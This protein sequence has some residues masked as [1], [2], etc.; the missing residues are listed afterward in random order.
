MRSLSLVILLPLAGCLTPAGEPTP[1]R[2]TLD[3]G[4]F[5]VGDVNEGLLTLDSPLGALDIPL[6]DIGEVEPVEGQD[7]AGSGDHVRVWLR[8][9]S[10]LV[11]RWSEPEL[12]VDIAIGGGVTAGA[13]PMAQVQR[14]QLTGEAAFPDAGTFRVK[15]AFGDDVFVDAAET[16]LPLDTQL[17]QL[18]PLL[19]E[20]ESLRPLDDQG[21]WRVQL[22]TGTVLNGTIATDTLTLSLRLG[23]PSIEVGVDDLLAV[24]RMTY[25][26]SLWSAPSPAEAMAE[27]DGWYDINA[28]GMSSQKRRQ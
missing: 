14:L 17:G 27:E 11:G 13:L 22:T 5:L 23:P 10:E 3:E 26:P 25:E 6:A 18:S 1:V 9:G 20:I 19:Q 15:T 12:D 24:D 7:L 21:R 4:Q 16:V 8:D 2:V 28:S